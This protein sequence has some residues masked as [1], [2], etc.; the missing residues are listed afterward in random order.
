MIISGTASRGKPWVLKP[1]SGQG[2]RS[3]HV[4]SLVSGTI[5][6]LECYW[7]LKDR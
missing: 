7:Q 5:V 4:Q 6:T 3:T 1:H 2:R